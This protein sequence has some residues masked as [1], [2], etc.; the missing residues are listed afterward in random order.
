MPNP[1]MWT[2]DGLE[3][4]WH[5]P[6]QAEKKNQ[7][8][9]FVIFFFVFHHLDISSSGPSWKKERRRKIIGNIIFSCSFHRCSQS[10]LFF[11]S[12]PTCNRLVDY[13]FYFFGTDWFAAVWVKFI[14]YFYFRC[15]QTVWYIL[16]CRVKM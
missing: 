15:A 4:L 3:I 10:V 14:L 11:V 2:P 16:S 9:D 7:F 8:Y 1:D 5:C 6:S 13:F 12:Q